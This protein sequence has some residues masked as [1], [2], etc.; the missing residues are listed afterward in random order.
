MPYPFYS[1]TKNVTLPILSLFQSLCKYTSTHNWLHNNIIRDEEEKLS[2]ISTWPVQF[3]FKRYMC[4]HTGGEMAFPTWFS[5][6]Y[7]ERGRA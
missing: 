3:T 4:H 5:T 2:K 6:R 1:G 7:M